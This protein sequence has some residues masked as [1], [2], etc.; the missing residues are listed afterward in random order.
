MYFPL[1]FGFQGCEKTVSDYAVDM[2][3]QMGFRLTWLTMWLVSGDKLPLPK[4]PVKK[5]DS[6]AGSTRS[7]SMWLGV[8]PEF[9]EPVS[10]TREA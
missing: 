7:Y 6:W 2:E 10:V 5:G 1:R 4:T 8:D 9:K 3:M